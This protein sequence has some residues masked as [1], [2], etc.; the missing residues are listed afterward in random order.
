VVMALVVWFAH[1]SE[2]RHR[3]PRLLPARGAALAHGAL[4]D[5][6]PREAAEV[7]WP[8][9][10]MGSLE[11]DTRPGCESKADDTMASMRDAAIR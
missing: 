11:Q 10:R 3:I 2:R 4:R 6:A 1:R 5:Q 7:S 9:V 8:R